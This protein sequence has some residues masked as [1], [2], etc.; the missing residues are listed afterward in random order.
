MSAPQPQENQWKI[1]AFCFLFLLIFTKSQLY[2]PLDFFSLIK[3]F[4]L[5]FAQNF[6]I[7]STIARKYYVLT[8]CLN[9]VASW[10]HIALCIFVSFGLSLFVYLRYILIWYISF[11]TILALILFLWIM[12]CVTGYFMFRLISTYLILYCQRGEVVIWV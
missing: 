8:K 6:T 11:L 7:L 2:F 4:V 12:F 9:F 3:P 10:F 1:I 5:V